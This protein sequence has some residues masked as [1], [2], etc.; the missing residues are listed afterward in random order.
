MSADE[1]FLKILEKLT[2]VQVE[3]GSVKAEVSHMKEDIHDI[4]LFLL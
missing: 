2:E 3:V 1:N 4:N